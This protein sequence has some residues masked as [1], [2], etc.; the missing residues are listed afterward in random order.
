VGVVVMRLSTLA[1]TWIFDLDGVLTPHNGYRSGPERLLPGVADFARRIAPQDTMLLLSSRD[2][3][4]REAS[5][6]FL[7]SAGLRVDGAIF[8]LPHG[9]RILFND[10]KPSGLAT[11][12]AINLGRDQGLESVRFVCDPSL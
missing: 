4:L 2:V 12:H 6:A 3:A 5:L 10:R 8:G 11:A 1:K 7:A 9:E